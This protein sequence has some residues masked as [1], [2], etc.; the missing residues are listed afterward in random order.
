M[1]GALLLAGCGGPQVGGDF[2]AY[3]T[4]NRLFTAVTAKRPDLVERCMADARKLQESNRMPPAALERLQEFA[5][6]ATNGDWQ[7]AA[8]GIK[9][10]AAKQ[11][12][13]TR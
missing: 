12:P 13:P 10:F 2:E 3:T 11:K 7:G 6:Q 1:A 8:A 5:S 4:I 9:R